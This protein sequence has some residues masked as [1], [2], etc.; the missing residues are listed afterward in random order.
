MFTATNLVLQRHE[1]PLNA[2]TTVRVSAG[3]LVWLRGENGVGKST[4]LKTLLGLLRPGRG[5][6]QWASPRP[7]IFYLGHELA[8]RPALTVLEQCRSHPAVNKHSDPLKALQA[9]G[10]TKYKHKLCAQLSRGQQQR[11][12]LACAILSEA[13]L[14]L[15]D[16]PLTALDVESQDIV[17]K[18][19]QA[20]C[21]AGGAVVVAS[22]NSLAD[23]ANMTV[24]LEA[25]A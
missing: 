24:T 21:Q 1:R 18:L 23:L 20:H 13:K 14:W 16:E 3:E 6:V 15:L 12:A 22:H 8:I 25:A 19:L 9:V 7:E 11:V 10:L 4:L 17:R 2:P 5:G